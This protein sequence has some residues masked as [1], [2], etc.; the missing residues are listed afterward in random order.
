VPSEC[1]LEC[2]GFEEDEENFE[3]SEL[4]LELESDP[5]E[6][7]RLSEAGLEGRPQSERFK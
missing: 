5:F 7:D 6:Q 4:E 3:E 2:S 1:V